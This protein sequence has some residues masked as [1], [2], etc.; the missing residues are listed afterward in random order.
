MFWG[1]ATAGDLHGAVCGFAPDVLHANDLSTLGAAARVSRHL[2]CRL[3]YDAHEYEA[4]RNGVPDSLAERVRLRDEKRFITHADAVVTVSDG[5]ADRLAERYGIPR[6]HVVMNAFLTDVPGTVDLRAQLGLEAAAKLAILTGAAQMGRG[7]EEAIAALSHARPHWHLAI[8][9][10]LSDARR[11]TLDDIARTH[12]VANRVHQL[13]EVEPD[14]VMSYARAADAALIPIQDT[15][16]AYRVALPN[17]LFQ[18]AFAHLPIVATPLPEIASWVRFADAGVVADGFAAVD[19][20]RALEDVEAFDLKPSIEL[21]AYSAASQA[22]RLC[23]IYAALESGR[24]LPVST[25]LPHRS[26]GTHSGI[27]LP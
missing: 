23:T 1:R 22:R 12:G 8:L 4:D 6:P 10:K 3:V 25:P 15:C 21:D 17:K 11:R 18:A 20:A 27:A 26:I 24:P 2:G 5:I 16:E 19:L 9:G 7:H 13:G 14:R